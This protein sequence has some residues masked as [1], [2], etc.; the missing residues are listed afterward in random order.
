MLNKQVLVFS[1][2][3]LFSFG[4]VLAVDDPV[5]SWSFENFP[6]NIVEDDTGNGFDGDLSDSFN[7]I[8]SSAKLGDWAVG[9]NNDGYI[10]TSNIGNSGSWE[11][12]I[13]FWL[14]IE[15]PLSSITS[16]IYYY[17]RTGA[18]ELTNHG[19]VLDVI[20]DI[21]G[22][23]LRYQP[24]LSSTRYQ[25]RLS[26][27]RLNYGEWYHIVT[28]INLDTSTF[29]GSSINNN[30]NL[31]VNNV[32]QNTTNSG[33]STSV[34]LQSHDRRFN[35]A[36]ANVGFKSTINKLVDQ[37]IVYNYTLSESEVSQ[38]YNQGFGLDPFDESQPQQVASIAPI[39]M[40]FQ[41]FADRPLNTFFIGETYYQ[42]EFAYN[43][44]T[45]TINAS[46]TANAGGFA[47]QLDS[48]GLMRVFSY[49]TPINQLPITV[50][51]CNQY[52]CA[53]T[54]VTLTIGSGEAEGGVI[55]MASVADLNLVEG[56]TGTRQFSFFFSNYDNRFI[57]FVDP[58]T[59]QLVYV[60]AGFPNDN[61][62]FTASINGDLAT[63]T[64][65]NTTCSV[66]TRLI[67]DDGTTSTPSNTFKVNVIAEQSG[68]AFVDNFLG[69]FPDPDT[70]PFSARMFYV[71]LT[72]LLTGVLAVFLVYNTKEISPTIIVMMTSL[73]LFFEVI[74]FTAIGYIPIWIIAVGAIGVL[75]IGIGWFSNRSVGAQ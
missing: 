57:E 74:F 43:L 7:M 14:R 53:S 17:G 12:T 21:D 51:A 47:V 67:A 1:L 27:L 70:L 4:I 3:L 39:G 69:I 42:V 5:L 54:T 2:V 34:T 23:N 31:Y 72:M 28:N 66:N 33:G 61:S 29:G 62:C 26:E 64:A 73:L 22:Y 45:Y 20:T 36:T 11:H 41:T 38:L 10:N 60:S 13:S 32:L 46:G 18:T 37:V 75:V 30:Y 9:I 6:A 40:N 59:N 65:K 63:W 48:T 15:D 49:N 71:V 19:F 55:G 8:T 50:R 25:G 35:L 16:P 44:A 56:Q 24:I 52:G 68:I 58:D